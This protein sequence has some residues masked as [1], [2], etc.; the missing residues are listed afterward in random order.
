M[1]VTAPADSTHVAWNDFN[2][3][4]PAGFTLYQDVALPGDS[5]AIAW[6]YRAQWTS[7]YS[8]NQ[9]R[10]A[11]WQLLDPVTGDTLATLHSFTT[12]PAAESPTGDTGWRS[13]TVPFAGA[14]GRVVR[15]QVT[16]SIP[17]FFPGPGQFEVDAFSMMALGATAGGDNP[18]SEPPSDPAEEELPGLDPTSKS[19][20]LKG[21][22]AAFGFKNQGQCVRFV[23]TG[24]DSR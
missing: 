2:A 10:T 13:I 22:W 24:K 18:P 7:D 16:Q 6:R 5:V 12:G 19:D 23:E 20:C 1:G 11:E 14:S 4:G 15:L 8:D 21:G 17:D 3:A 9:P